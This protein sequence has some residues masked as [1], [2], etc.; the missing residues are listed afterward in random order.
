MKLFCFHHYMMQRS[1]CWK[2]F[3]IAHHCSFSA[4]SR[5]PRGELLQHHHLCCASAP[6]SHP[7]RSLSD[8][9]GHSKR[10]NSIPH[11]EPAEWR[12]RHR[13]GSMAKVLLFGPPLAPV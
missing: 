9:I 12:N 6:A 3:N 5:C 1:T 7:R 2:M 11:T 13:L 8:V 4:L 10:S